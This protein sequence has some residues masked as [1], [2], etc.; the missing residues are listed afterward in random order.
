MIK[1]AKNSQERGTEVE[2]EARLTPPDRRA[3]TPDD[4]VDVLAGGVPHVVYG[5]A[6]VEP[7]VGRSDRPQEQHGP[8]HLSA[9]GEGPR[10]AG[11][12]Y[13]WGGEPSDDLT[14]EEHI[15]AG[16]HHHRVVDGE[17]D[18]GRSCGGG[19]KH[20]H[21]RQNG[22]DHQEEIPNTEHVKGRG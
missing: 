15:L 14:V 22:G 17:P 16:V 7:G 20:R 8:P 19:G 10:V 11:P 6:V 1:G 18:D 9:E 21:R 3:L 13:C 12:G 2:T 4:E 5:G